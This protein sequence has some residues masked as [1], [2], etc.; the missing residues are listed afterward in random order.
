MDNA[1]EGY[2]Y[3]RTLERVL[4]RLPYKLKSEFK[5]LNDSRYLIKIGCLLASTYDAAY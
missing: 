5:A 2:S 4:E 1:C 3:P